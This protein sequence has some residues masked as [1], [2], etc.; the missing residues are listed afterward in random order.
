[1]RIAY[2]QEA[3]VLLI[4]L[5]EGIPV[6]SVDL[7]ECMIVHYDAGE[8]P[9]EIEILDASRLVSLDEVDVSLKEM[10]RDRELVAK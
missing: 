4:K 6:D 3:D 5:R 7:S 10:L 9:I 1:M 8:R 2:S